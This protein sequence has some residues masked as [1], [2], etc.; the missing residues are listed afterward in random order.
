MW[1]III[2]S[3]WFN[4]FFAA[5]LFL[6]VGCG[7]LYAKRYKK[8]SKWESS[9]IEN[10]VVGIFGLIISFTFLQAGNAHRERSA[11]IHREANSIN[12]LFQYSKAMPD[13]FF[14]FTKNTLVTFLN[15]QITYEQSNDEQ[16]FYNAKKISDSYWVYLIKYNEQ[17]GNLNNAKQLDKITLCFDQ[18]QTSV[19]LLAYSYYERT[20]S[21]IMF[22]L[23]IVSLLIGFLIGFMNGMKLNVHYL[24]PIIYF[25]MITLTMAVINDLNNPRIGLIKP[26]YHHLKMTYEN[27]KNN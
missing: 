13:S 4:F 9:G 14:K 12:M 2:D 19:S 22:L 5:V 17:T 25:V 6:S 10:S 18:I 26:S 21:F 16:F 11:N 27:I 24:V 8:K 15:N 23:V 3:S 1:Q 7:I 20:P